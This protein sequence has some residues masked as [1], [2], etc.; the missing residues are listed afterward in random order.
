[1]LSY[2]NEYLRNLITLSFTLLC[3]TNNYNDN[4]SPKN[5]LK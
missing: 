5:F 2:Y 1:M 3:A 4:S